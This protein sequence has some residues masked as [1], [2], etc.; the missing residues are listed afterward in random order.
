[1]QECQQ[2][3]YGKYVVA[4][5]IRP[6]ATFIDFAVMEAYCTHIMQISACVPNNSLFIETRA[7]AGRG[8]PR[9]SIAV[10]YDTYAT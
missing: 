5:G 7:A 1:M 8:F 10:E 6:T 9:F 3:L 2:A 4:I